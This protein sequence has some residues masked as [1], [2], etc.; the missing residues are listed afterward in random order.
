MPIPTQFDRKLGEIDDLQAVVMI[1]LRTLQRA[2]VRGDPDSVREPL[3]RYVDAVKALAASSDEIVRSILPAARS[4][5][6][7]PF[8]AIRSD[9][10]VRHRSRRMDYLVARRA[11][12]P[13]G[14]LAELDFAR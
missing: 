6:E 12:R 3:D 10:R 11:D 1:R 14:M 8:G 13:D 7:E 2:G 4:G 9:E 5:G